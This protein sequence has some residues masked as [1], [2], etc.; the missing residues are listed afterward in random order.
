MLLYKGMVELIF[1]LLE[2]VQQVDVLIFD[3]IK[4]KINSIQKP[5]GLYIYINQN[6]FILGTGVD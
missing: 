3:K 6:G 2:G 5:I 1:T 4:N